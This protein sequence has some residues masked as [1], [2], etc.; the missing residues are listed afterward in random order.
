MKLLTFEEAKVAL[1]TIIPEPHPA[2]ETI[3]LLESLHRIAAKDIFSPFP[4]PSFKNSAMDG[5]AIRLKDTADGSPLP[6]AGTLLAGHS[7][8]QYWPPKSCFKIMTGAEVP[9]EADAVVM[10]EDAE[11]KAEGIY[12]HKYIS[13]QQHIRMI[14]E[15]ISHN[16]K[17]ISQGQRLTIPL[18]SQLST[19][20]VAD[21]TVFKR[22][23]IALF[24]TGDE[25]LTLDEA[26]LPGKIYDTNRITLRLLLQQLGCD[27]LDLGIIQDN[28]QKITRT[29]EN[30]A[31]NS[32]LIIT[33][34]GVSVGDADYIRTVLEKL[35][36]IHFWKIAIKPGKPFAY[37]EI[38]KTLFCALPGNPISAFTTFYHLV[39]P[40]I[41]HLMGQSI[42]SGDL[43][44]FKVRSLNKLYKK[45]GRVDFQRGRLLAN[46]QGELYV[47]ST[48]QQ[49]SHLT[50]S[51]SS[52]NC[53]IIL[54]LSRSDVEPGDWVTVQPFNHIVM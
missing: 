21:I 49:Q 24:S 32:D 36:T 46:E 30:A 31:Q 25:L 11:Q 35:G 51:F 3:P 37:G 52:A 15:D 12:F 43:P 1:L 22:L 45:I 33:S 53:F 7:S 9:Q 19:L 28:T 29:L 2:I 38:N 6:V 5:F 27:V 40:L 10:L 48:G 54:E 26:P 50:R 16:Q 17:I 18:L 47:E 8:N 20:G 23:K 42:S 13:P 39:Q 41:L 4:I 34:G 44:Q 14:G